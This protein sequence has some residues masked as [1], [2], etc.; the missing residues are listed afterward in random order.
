[1][2]KLSLILLF[3]AASSAAGAQTLPARLDS[4]GT[5]A[6][7]TMHWRVRPLERG[8]CTW[9]IV[10]NVAS[11]DCFD[12][13]EI[14]L[15]DAHYDDALG[16]EAA[17]LRVFSVR[18][19]VLASE[20]TMPFAPSS[21][22]REGGGSLRLRVARGN[23]HAVLEAGYGRPDI[24]M[25][26]S[27]GAG[28]RVGRY[29]L[30]KADTLRDELRV[31]RLPEPMFA[32]FGS[33]GELRAHLAASDDVNEAEWV[34]YDRDTDPRRLSLGGDYRFATVSDGRGGYD[35]VL[36]S[37][38]EGP[39]MR[40]KGRLRPTGFIGQYDLDWL[41]AS[42]EPMGP[43][44]SALMTDASLLTLRFPLYGG[45]VRYRRAVATD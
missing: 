33:V 18:D 26:V 44:C 22:M 27:L 11:A 15:H 29:V 13:A 17:E 25:P 31:E 43:E 10:W 45:S 40:I 21:S 42:G 8:K 12:G 23:S 16:R 35:I 9:G 39:E 28:S 7:M 34:Y 2:R 38:S 19:G 5:P 20:Q 30:C 3:A 24:S 6:E 36:I 41:D 4:I 37:G 14:T 32:S 1:M